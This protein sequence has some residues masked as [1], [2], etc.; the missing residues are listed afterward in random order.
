MKSRLLFLLCSAAALLIV[1]GYSLERD[2]SVSTADFP[3]LEPVT[4]D[5]ATDLHVLAPELTDHG[6]Y[7]QRVV[8]NA[9]GKMTAYSEELLEAFVHQVIREAPE[10]L[11][12]SGDLTFNGEAASHRYLA[13]ALGRIEEAGIP[14]FVL[15]GNHDLDNPM[16]A[17]FAGEGW[18]P[19]ES[20]TAGDFAEIYR[21]FGYGEA[22]TRDDASLSYAVE[23]APHLRLLLVDVNAAEVPGTLSAQT[24][25]WVEE[26]LRDAAEHS[27][28]VVAVS[29]QNLLAHNRLFTQGFVMGNANQLLGLY[30]RYPVICNLSGHIHL[31]HI[32]E[33]AGGPKEIV[34]SSLAVSP[35]QHGA[36]RLEGTAADYRTVPVDVAGWAREQGCQ[37]P[38]LL[39]F[40][41]T[42][43]QFFR[44]T[45]YRQ[46]MEAVRGTPN[47]ADLAG[48]FA[49]VNAAYFA[50]R[51]DT[52]P[53]DDALF[54]DWQAR[55]GF[56][57]QYLAS[58]QDEGFEN[59]TMCKFSFGGGSYGTQ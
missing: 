12:L 16:A 51:M 8:S 40:P 26:Q 25:S 13:A 28:W 57:S 5:L 23:L 17:E 54:D 48:F 55:D 45:G 22:L 6:A 37:D 31:Q 19:V 59:Q 47:A 21:D 43:R 11:I 44:D 1:Y 29:H 53:W 30:Q 14:V 4:L 41:D 52:A 15:P 58:I 10:A 24:L 50:G 56:L 2:R 18:R 9:D 20:V 32:A 34:T 33:R 27:A 46:A 36:L 3:E 42:S 49:E 38:A 7:F 35:H 39:N